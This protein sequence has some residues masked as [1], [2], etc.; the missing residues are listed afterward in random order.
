VPDVQLHDLQEGIRSCLPM[1]SLEGFSRFFTSCS[2]MLG[3]A[4]SVETRS[5]MLSSEAPMASPSATTRAHQ[6][7]FIVGDSSRLPFFSFC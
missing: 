3:V 5:P 6:N 2:N 7:A 1:Y 4:R